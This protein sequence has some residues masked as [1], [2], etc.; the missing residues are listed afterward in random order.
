[1]RKEQIT[2]VSAAVCSDLALILQL[3]PGVLRKPFELKTCL[4]ESVACLNC[5]LTQL[6]RGHNTVTRTVKC[7]HSEMTL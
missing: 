5:P 6:T 3:T 7:R 1:M 4:V 2:A